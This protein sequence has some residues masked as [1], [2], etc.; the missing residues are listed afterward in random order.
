MVKT[1]IHNILNDQKVKMYKGTK[2]IGN[3]FLNPT[4]VPQEII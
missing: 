3:N 1:H 4:L 2:G